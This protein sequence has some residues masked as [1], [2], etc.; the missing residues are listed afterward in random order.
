MLN[1]AARCGYAPRVGMMGSRWVVAAFVVTVFL[2]A[3]G[4]PVPP[5]ANAEQA[6]VDGAKAK[7]LFTGG[8]FLFD[9]R[10][11]DEYRVDHIEGADNVPLGTI[12]SRELGAKDTPIIL[13]CDSGARA[14]RAATILRSKG[15]TH[16]YE[17]G[18]MANWN[19]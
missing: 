19:R 18:A 10:S 13:Y 15:Y 11:P 14:A 1:E 3:C 7:K 6:H 16:V 4:P 2:G 17:L 5:A 9:V 8:A 12:E